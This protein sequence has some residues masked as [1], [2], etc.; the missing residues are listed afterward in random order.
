MP[1]RGFPSRGRRLGVEVGEGWCQYGE[2]GSPAT[3]ADL[4]QLELNSRIITES[5]RMRPPGWIFTRVTTQEAQ[6][7]RYRLPAGTAVLYSQYLAHHRPDVFRDPDHFDPDRWRDGSPPPGAFVP[8]AI[9]A[10]KCIGDTF[11]TTE[12]TLA[13]A[14]ITARWKP[15]PSPGMKVRS[16]PGGLVLRPDGLRMV[17]EARA[18]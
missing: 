6:L 14:T 3:Y 2:H 13:L 11:A 9:G 8:F 17:M 12:A 5:L 16:T 15:K 4:P 18:G 1:D 7:G 10:R